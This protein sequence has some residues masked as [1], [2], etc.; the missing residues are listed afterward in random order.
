LQVTY[1]GPLA[2]V[3][4]ANGNAGNNNNNNNN[5]NGWF[6]G[7]L[8]CFRPMWMIIGKQK[9]NLELETG[10][11]M[12]YVFCVLVYNLLALFLA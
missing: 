7:I 9:P 12:E 5:N 4:R 3:N 8:G 11:T 6:D 1:R 10:K 2:P